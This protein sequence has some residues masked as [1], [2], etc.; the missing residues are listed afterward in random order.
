[1]KAH[2][3]DSDIPILEGSTVV[4]NCGQHVPNCKFVMMWDAQELDEIDLGWMRN[5]CRKCIEQR[6]DRRYIYGILNGQELKHGEG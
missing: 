4:V 2:L 1:M 6:V 5:L 3:L